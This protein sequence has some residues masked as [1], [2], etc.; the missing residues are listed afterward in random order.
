MKKSIILVSVLSL[1]AIL[2]PSCA[3]EPKATT[4]TTRQTTATAQSQTSLPPQPIGYH[5][6]NMETGGPALTGGRW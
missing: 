5:D 1:A 2:L 3:N 6:N 4:A